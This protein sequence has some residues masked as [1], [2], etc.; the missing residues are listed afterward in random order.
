G[1]RVSPLAGIFAV[2]VKIDAGRLLEGVASLGT[3][4]TIDAEAVEPLLEVHVF[5]FDGDLYG[6]YVEV[7]FISRL[8]DERRFPDLAA[9]C[10]QMDLDAADARRRLAAE[11]RC[12][13]AD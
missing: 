10:R 8:R 12:R 3:R 13:P 6:R 4:P 2:R 9:L 11:R 1:R 7:E 5:D